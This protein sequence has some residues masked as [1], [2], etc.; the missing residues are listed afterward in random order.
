MVTPSAYSRSPPTGSPRA[1]RVTAQRIAAPAAAGRRARSPPPRGSDWWPG[2]P[3]GP[4]PAPPAARAGGMVRSSGVMP[5]SGESRPPS[6]WYCPRNSP[7]RSIAPMSAASS[8]TQMSAGS[9]RGSR[10]I[11]AQLLLREVEAARAGPNLLRERL[12]RRR[13][14][15]GSA[16]AAA[17]AGGR[18]AAAPSS[19]RCPAAAPARWSGRRSPTRPA[20]A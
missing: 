13:R 15:A 6:T 2:S 9:R 20:S 8:T 12:E 3:R 1:I 18:S 4:P 17:S 5:S 7:A 10:Q 19:A 16:P 11:D 14:A